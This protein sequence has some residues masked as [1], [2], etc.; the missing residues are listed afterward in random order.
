M[1]MR[2]NGAILAVG[3]IG[4][5]HVRW[6][7]GGSHFH[8]FFYGRPVGDV[9]MFGF[10]SAMWAMVRPPMPDDEWGRNL[11]VVATELAREGGRA[12]V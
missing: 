7:D 9:Q 5:V 1:I 3:G 12:I 11:R 6:G 2:L 10:C 8:A 4:R